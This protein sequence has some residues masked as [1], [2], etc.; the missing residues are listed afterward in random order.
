M[1]DK[2]KNI[3]WY[4]NPNFIT[5]LAISVLVLI[6]VLSQSFAVKNNIGTNDILR[7]LLNHNSVYLLGLIYFIP[8]KTLSGKKYFNYLNIF[9]IIIYGVFSITSVL[10]II[11]SFGLT[12]LVGLAINIVL[13]VYIIHTLLVDTRLWKDFKLIK[14]PLNEIK[15]ENY[16]YTLVILSIILLTVNLIQTSTVAGAIISLFGCIYVCILSRYIY[17]Y[18]VHIELKR[19]NKDNKNNQEIRNKSNSKKQED[20]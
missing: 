15:K 10:T 1:E 3:Y 4:N 20:I 5:T 2:K 18:G 19:K 6:I 17:L 12:S 9:L 8:L 16:Y 7:S 11:Q 13:L 14:S